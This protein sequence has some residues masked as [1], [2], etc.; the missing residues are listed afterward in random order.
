MKGRIK[1]RRKSNA[2]Y[3]ITKHPGITYEEHYETEL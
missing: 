1:G 3:R 2:A